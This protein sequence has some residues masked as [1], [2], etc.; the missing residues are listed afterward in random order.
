MDDRHR[1]N[2]AAAL[3]SVASN[4]VQAVV[5]LAIGLLTGS[6]AV[7]S[8][9]ANSA[10]DLVAS[11]IAFAGVRA[12]ARPADEDHPYGHEKSENLAAAAEGA[13]VLA[14]GAAVAVEAVRRLLE[15][16]TAIARLDLAIAVMAGSALVNVV[17]A[18]RLRRVARRTGS[19]AI[20][21]DAAHI[22]SDVFTSAGAAFGLALV[23]VTGWTP[24]D[25]IVALA[26]AG[27]VVFVGGRLAWRAVQVLMDR[28]LPDD[29][30]ATIAGVLDDFAG[31]DGV[32]FHA[33]RGRRAGSKRHVDLHMVV[34]PETT[35]RE[36]HAL[37]GR[38][39]SA[40]RRALP[41]TDVLIHLED[42][43]PRATPVSEEAGD[44][45][46]TTGP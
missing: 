27:Y 5:K 28:A 44:R 43:S 18:A 15:G 46:R 23:A 16:G 21:A 14:A 25:A 8:D 19:P 32:S 40:V 35:V 36:G 31:E 29:E 2:R 1:Q 33:L 30:L 34:P 9:A 22:G 37:S 13:L 45:R 17:V 4:A 26:I 7:L 42:H 24:L 39:K 20:E 38:V 41:D 3:L 6:V 11:G 12:A 10:G